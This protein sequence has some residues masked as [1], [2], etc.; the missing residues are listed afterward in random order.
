MITRQMRQPQHYAVPGK[1][2]TLLTYFYVGGPLQIM[3]T[4][5]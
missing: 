4:I 1:E 3:G 5:C 2:S